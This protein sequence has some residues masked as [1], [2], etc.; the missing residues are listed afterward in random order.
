M[1]YKGVIVA[2]RRELANIIRQTNINGNLK[3][4]R[5]SYNWRHDATYTFLWAIIISTLFVLILQTIIHPGKP[6]LK[7]LLAINGLFV[8]LITLFIGLRPIFSLFTIPDTLYINDKGQLL[9]RDSEVVSL[10]NIQ[11]LEINEVGA[12]KSHLIYYE[13]TFNKAPNVLRNKKRKSLILT[14]PYNI[15]YIFQSRTDLVDRLIDLGLAEDKIKTKQYRIRHF[16]G[17]RDKFKK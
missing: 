5:I 14:E 17:I 15:K 6:L 3:H 9:T 16:F 12:T 1:L 2:F 7:P 13:M 10:D 4:N 11:T 8:P